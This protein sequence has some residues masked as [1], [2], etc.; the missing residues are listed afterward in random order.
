MPNSLMWWLILFCLGIAIG[1]VAI[2]GAEAFL[3]LFVVKRLS[4]KSDQSDRRTD[5][6]DHNQS[7]DFAYNKQVFWISVSSLFV[8]QESNWLL[9]FIPKW[10]VYI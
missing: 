2:L 4:R 3:L 9:S 8:S 10:R 6:L 5:H 7:L 1:A